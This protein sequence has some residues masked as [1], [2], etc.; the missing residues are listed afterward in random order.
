MGRLRTEN[1]KFAALPAPCRGATRAVKSAGKKTLPGLFLNSPGGNVT[2]VTSAKQDQLEVWEDAR[3]LAREGRF[4]EIRADLYVR[5]D[6]SFKRIR[7][8]RKVEL[9]T[10]Q[11]EMEHTWFYGD[12]GSGKSRQAREMY[13]NA[14]EKGL[15]KWWDDYDHEEIVLIE[16]WD[17]DC[18][19]THLMKRWSDRYPFR[20][21][22][23]GGSMMLR[24]RVIVVTSN[25]SPEECFF[26]KDAKA[27]I[28]RFK[29]IKV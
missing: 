3:N 18:R 11:G 22:I 23:K 24:P 13:P 10:I 8:E 19:L 27:I 28:R 9:K 16:E 26:G 20:G 7:A 5:Y 25:Y 1:R 15:N 14:Y 2:N 6:R 29:V 12:P 17:P 21:E 4:D